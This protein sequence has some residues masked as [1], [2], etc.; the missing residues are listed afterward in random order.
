VPPQGT[1]GERADA[2]EFGHEGNGDV[3]TETCSLWIRAGLGLGPCRIQLQN[4]KNI[5]LLKLIALRCVHFLEKRVP[6][7]FP[8]L[9]R[10]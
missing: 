8:Y 6:E 4:N 10:D 7:Q 2:F 3:K 5:N 1:G 9:N